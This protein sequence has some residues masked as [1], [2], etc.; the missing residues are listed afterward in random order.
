LGKSQFQLLQLDKIVKNE[1]ISKLAL[2]INLL[3]Y[4]YS[5]KSPFSIYINIE[6]LFEPTKYRIIKFRD[7]LLSEKNYT[8]FLTKS[9]IDEIVKTC[10]KNVF[11]EIKEKSGS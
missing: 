7:E 2:T 8:Q 1:P 10:V 3:D 11:E 9:E 4:L 6:I 5:I